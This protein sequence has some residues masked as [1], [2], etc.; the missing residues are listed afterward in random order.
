MT[1]LA[2]SRVAD[3]SARPT[4]RAIRGRRELLGRRAWFGCRRFWSR[5]ARAPWNCT[6]GRCTPQLTGC[7]ASC[8]T[9]TARLFRECRPDIGLPP[10]RIREGLRAPYVPAVH[11]VHGPDGLPVTLFNN[12]GFSLAVERLLGIEVPLPWPYCAVIMCELCRL[13]SHL[14]WYGRARSTSV[15]LPPSCTHG[16]TARSSLTSNELVSGVRM[17]TS[18]I[19]VGGLLADVPDPFLRDGRGGHQDLPK[20]DREHELLITKNPIWRQRTIGLGQADPRGRDGLWRHR[21]G[22]PGQWRSYDLRKAQPYSSYD[23]LDFDVPIGRTGD[24]YDRYLGPHAGD[25]GVAEDI[26]PKGP[27]RTFPD[28]PVTRRPAGRAPTAQRASTP[29]WSP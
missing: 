5:S 9:S 20:A 4:Q 18:F 28:G 15:R 23:H 22:A 26:T 29:A 14:L 1:A 11:P 2:A 3:R 12:L 7:S 10:H 24:V 17:H 27:S 8:S 25:A 19:R 21:S 16:A 13:A 6:W